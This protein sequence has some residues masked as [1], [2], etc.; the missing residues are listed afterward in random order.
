MSRS[1]ISLYVE[2][3]LRL[4]IADPRERGSVTPVEGL[5]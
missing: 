2:A 1:S 3:V 5:L 4:P